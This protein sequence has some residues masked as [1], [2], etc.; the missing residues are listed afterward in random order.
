M[1]FLGLAL[2]AEGPT[3][4][5]FLHAVLRRVCED[6][7]QREANDTV[8]IGEV[9]PLRVPAGPSETDL[10]CCGNLRASAPLPMT[11]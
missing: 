1:R 4:H 6:V 11:W 10:P 7:C 8:E 9:L 2:I 3:D 5:R